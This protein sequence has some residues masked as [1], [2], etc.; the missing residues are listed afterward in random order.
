M[1]KGELKSGGIASKS[2]SE[3]R[4]IYLNELREEGLV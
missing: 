2:L 3:V 4:A 1:L